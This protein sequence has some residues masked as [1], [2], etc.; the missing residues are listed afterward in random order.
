MKGF[1]RRQNGCPESVGSYAFRGINAMIMVCIAM[2]MLY[3]FLYVVFASISDPNSLIRHRG[4][5]WKPYGVQLDAYSLVL[6]NPNIAM[7]YLNTVFYV[8]LGTVINMAMTILSAFVLARR[9]FLLRKPLTLMALITMYFSGGMIPL[10]LQVNRL[11]LL[12]SV[13]ALLLPTAMSTYN[14]IIMR[15]AFSNIPA[16]LEES[17]FLDGANE[18]VILFRI[19]V[20]LSMATL[21]VMVLFYSVNIWNGWFNAMIYLQDRKL[22]P[23][24]LILREILIANDTSSMTVGMTGDKV[25][26]AESVK[27]ATIVVATLPVL[28]IYPFL[29]KYFVKGVMIGAL[30]G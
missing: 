12:N 27:Y 11:G 26:L 17:A 6:N 14:L 5:L 18:W 10:Y 21:A 8:V 2:I 22:F 28:C 7:G 20:P 15:T 16:E 13:W 23:L 19:V 24:Q 1:G 4:I 30:K 3:P 9:N 25:P 29:Q